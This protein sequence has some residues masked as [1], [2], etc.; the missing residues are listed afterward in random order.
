[1]QK[2]SADFYEK[3][4]GNR[5]WNFVKL[6]N[7]VIVLREENSSRIRTLCWNYLAEYKNYEMK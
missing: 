1:M 3:N 5:I 6:I 2:K 7:E 4:Y